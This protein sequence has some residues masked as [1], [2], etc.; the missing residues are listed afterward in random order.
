MSA[1]HDN[2]LLGASGQQ[3]YKISRSV[4]LRS[5]AS[6]Y[7]NRTFGSGS[8]TT[9][10]WNCWVKRGAVGVVYPTT[11]YAQALFG[12][13]DSDKIYFYED[14]LW[15][16]L[17]TGATYTAQ[18][19]DKFRDPSAWYHIVV[20]LDTTNATSGDRVRIYVNNRRVTISQTMPTQNWASSNFNSAINHNIGKADNSNLYYLD[21]YLT[22]IHFIDGQ[23]LTP[24]S[25][26]E[27]DTAT[28]VWKPKKYTG[29]YGTNG[30]YLNFS[31]N[32]SNTAAT[33]GKDYSGNGNNWTPNNISV[34]SG[35]TY[36]S[37]VDSPTVGATSSNYAVLNPL[38]AQGTA[39]LSDANL[40]IASSTTAHKNRKSTFLLPSS[41]KWY[42]EL[43]T[44]STCSASIILGWGLQTTSAA[45]DSQGGNANTW[46]AQNDANQDIFNQTTTVLS[47][48][49]AVTGGSIRQVAYDADTGKLWFGVNNTW[50][51]ST[52]LTSGNPS[53]GTNQCMTLSAGDY[54]PTVTCYNLTANV[55]F[56]QRPFAYTPPTGFVALNTQNLPTP[57]ISNGANYMNAS[58][59]TGDAST[60][61]A[62]VSNLAFSPDLVWTKDRSVGYQHSLQDTVRGTGASKKLYSSLTEAEN[63]ANAVYGHINSFDSNGFTVATG[64]SGAQHVNASG[65]TYV[66]WSWKAG[67]A[68]SSNTSGSIT[69]TVSAG[70]TQGFSVVTYTGNGSAGATCGHG[71]GVTPAMVIWKNRSGTDAWITYHR[72]L[73]T[74]EYLV[75]NTTAAK[76]TYSGLFTGIS[77]TLLPL[78]NASAAINA[79]ANNYV[80][81]CFAEVAGYSKFGS[82]TGN[83]SAD[84]VFVFLGF[85]PRWVMIK[86]TDTAGNSW[87]IYDSSRVAYNPDELVL[88]PNLSNLE[89]SGVPIDIL[90]NGF[91]QRS[92]WTNGNASGATYI[93]AAFA[94]NPFKISLA[95]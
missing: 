10:T 8:R 12:L 56:G 18:P 37:M 91:K 74:S 64:S 44:S 95:R 60:P 2:A 63:G 46:M 43:T 75:L 35:V 67:G 17:G 47:T 14:A 38:D 11:N 15:V 71:L 62:V 73:T 72:A 70:A 66:G 45:T 16:Y 24:S 50:Y 21:A 76:A 80:A 48:G 39:T 86:R 32:S 29:T 3:G 13:N 23:A 27:T 58:L 78:N 6:A 61:R 42:W 87:L 85:R 41:G 19:S 9:W 51:S 83:G 34:T 20:V 92:T 5:S 25:F 82:Y 22:E 89:D 94:E 68:S 84:G 26:G 77:S 93:F 69:S 53:S 88:Y 40:T 49:S 36:D 4:R 81:Y 79:S 30:F 54:F 28:G 57:T 33:I 7:L 52:D 65:V 55:N 31:D 59:W 1:F 90:S